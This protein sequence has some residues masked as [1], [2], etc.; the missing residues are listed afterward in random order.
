[1][2]KTS[3]LHFPHGSALDTKYVCASQML[4]DEVEDGGIAS[5]HVVLLSGQAKNMLPGS[6]TYSLPLFLSMEWN[7]RLVLSQTPVVV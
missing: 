2:I 7:R 4:L 5:I 6:K 3:S 1:M